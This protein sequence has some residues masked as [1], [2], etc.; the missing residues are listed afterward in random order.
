MFRG[1]FPDYKKKE[2]DSSIKR[3]IAYLK[4][5]QR[6]DGSWYDLPLE[7]FKYYSGLDLGL[8]A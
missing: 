7:L 5:N 4:K 6:A 1:I 8:F 2:V 3:G